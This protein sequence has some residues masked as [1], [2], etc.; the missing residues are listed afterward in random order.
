VKIA[1]IAA[2]AICLLAACSSAVP[3]P[4][5]APPVKAASD[6]SAAQTKASA[7]SPVAAPAPKPSAAVPPGGT[8]APAAQPAG[9]KP[10][11][12]QWSQPPAMTIDQNK[13]YTA[14]IKTNMGD[15]KVQLLPKESPSAVNNF[16]FLAREGFYDGIKF[17]RVIKGFM[18]QTGDPRGTGTGG[19]GYQFKDELEAARSRGYKKGIVAMANSGPNTNGSQF[20]IMDADYALP[21]N[22][23]VFGQVIEGQDVV[24][25]IASVAVGPGAGGRE[26]SSPTVDVRMDAVTVQES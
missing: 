4:T 2:A 18:V 6:S 21:P 26:V 20:F 24:N 1:L 25:K 19:P 13:N 17:H 10:V 22:Y 3:T 8:A 11:A 14:T 12:K 16:V 5:A 7:A 15:V 23:V 9:G